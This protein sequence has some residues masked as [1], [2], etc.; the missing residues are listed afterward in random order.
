LFAFLSSGFQ[1]NGEQDIREV[2]SGIT[3]VADETGC[4]FVLV[5]HFNKKEDLSAVYGGGGNIGITAQAR[6]GFAL[7]P[8]PDRPEQATV[9]AWTKNNLSDRSLREA[10]VFKNGKEPVVEEIDQPVLKYEGKETWTADKLSFGGV[11]AARPPSRQASGGQA[12]P[13]GRT[14]G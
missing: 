10:L 13:P 14:G 2:L 5:R 4:A 3:E 9:L 11:G 12:V 7:A 1:K 6:L 8:H